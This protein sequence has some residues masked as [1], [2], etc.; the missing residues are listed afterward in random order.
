[1]KIFPAIDIINGKAVRL[2]RGDYSKMTVFNDNPVE[3]A[4]DFEKKG[5]K[6]I[7][8]VDLDGAKSGSLD[9]IKTV[10]KIVKETRLFVEI[11]GGIRNKERIEKYLDLGVGRVILGTAAANNF[12]FLKESVDEFKE[13]IVLGVDAKDGLVAINGWEKK[14]NIDSFEFCEKARDIGVKTVIYTDIAKD[15]AMQGTNIEAFKRLVKIEGLDII[16]SG[17]VSNL[18]D[19]KKLKE[20]NVYGAII[21]KALYL[22]AIDLKEA[23]SDN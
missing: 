11:G 18:D 16:A 5:A 19:L 17:G 6:Y 1:M 12:E 2:T 7:H 3:V 10:E 14:T 13:K 22:G 4:K 20:I 21:G 23:L 9:N 8:L 15:G